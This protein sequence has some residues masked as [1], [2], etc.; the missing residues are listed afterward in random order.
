MAVAMKAVREQSHEFSNEERIA[1]KNVVGA[2]CSS[3]RVTPALSRKQRKEK[4]PQV[5]R[6]YHEKMEAELQDFCNDVLEM[7][8]KYLTPNSIQPERKVFYLKM[9]GDYFRYLSEVA[10]GDNK[11]T[12]VELPAG[13]SGTI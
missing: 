1:Y 7:L 4:K 12:T 5:G 8:D 6:E 10:S 2:C 13:L 11:Q 3:W 9:K